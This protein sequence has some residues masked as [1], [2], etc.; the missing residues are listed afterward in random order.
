MV[1]KQEPY[2][3]HS[4]SDLIRECVDLHYRNHPQQRGYFT[5]AITFRA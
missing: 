4:F 5:I 1:I 2:A 3:S